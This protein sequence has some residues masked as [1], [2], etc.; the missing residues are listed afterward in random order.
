M[1]IA[2]ITALISIILIGAIA[3]SINKANIILI[4]LILCSSFFGLVDPLSFT[5]KGLFDIHLL[6]F[7]LIIFSISISFQR[8]RDLKNLKLGIPLL[9]LVL[10]LIY[11]IFIPVIRDHSTFFYSFKSSKEFLMILWYFAAFLY[12]NKQKDIDLAWN[13]LIGL[14]LYYTM[15]ESI[16]QIAAPTLS[17]ILSYNF[18]KEF[19]IFWKV[20][21]PFWPVILILLFSSFYQI[22]FKIKHNY[23]LLF[24]GT[25]GLFLTFFR[26]Y[27]LASIAVIPLILILH[28]KNKFK[29]LSRTII[30]GISIILVIIV[31]I[32]TMGDKN[33]L[34]KLTD[35]FIISGITEIS[36]QSGGA[37]AGREI[38]SKG[39]YILRDQ[40]PLTGYGFIEKDSSF[41]LI[42]RKQM[43]GISLGFI[44]K[45][46]LDVTLKFGYIGAAFLY[47][48]YLMIAL[49]LVKLSKE[50]IS[51]SLKARAL[52]CASLSI[53][54]LIVQPVHAPLS[55][56]FSLLPFMIAL[57]LIERQ[58]FIEKS[59]KRNELINKPSYEEKENKIKRNKYDSVRLRRQQ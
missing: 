11:G 2:I 25:I 12:I 54:F 9:I 24:A 1:N 55:N 15:I 21:P 22:I 17:N 41:G 26:S 47:F 18:R 38:H 36:E 49:I 51:S 3:L 6:F 30:S 13:Y 20:Y 32:L 43:S 4:V 35:R 28:G 33:I 19:F 23:S 52:T 37:L 56:S 44:D 53:V 10:L 42:T 39:K 58:Y 7:L 48:A 8:L 50:D 29:Y 34:S 46:T 14:G 57:G 31:L 16:A 59:N 40:Q 45:G 27:F 5:A